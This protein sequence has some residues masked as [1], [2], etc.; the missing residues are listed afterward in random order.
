MLSFFL[1][2][3][4]YFILQIIEKIYKTYNPFN[5]VT[6]L[7]FF[8]FFSLIEGVLP[9]CRHVGEDLEVWGHGVHLLHADHPGRVKR[10]GAVEAAR[11]VEHPPHV[12]HNRG[13]KVDGLVEAACRSEHVPHTGHP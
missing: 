8:T 12:S 2:L 5:L 1:V 6:N 11:C 9:F 10:D 13:V 7:I 3:V 4:K